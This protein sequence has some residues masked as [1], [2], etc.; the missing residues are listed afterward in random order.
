MILS[1]VVCSADAI[2]TFP[3]APAYQH[4]KIKGLRFVMIV[5][6][7]G[8]ADTTKTMTVKSD[9]GVGNAFY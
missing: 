8:I 4:Y 6:R 7:L 3:S 5:I 1:P 9:R 2:F